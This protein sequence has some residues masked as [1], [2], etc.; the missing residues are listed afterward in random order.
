MHKSLSPIL[1]EEY[2]D[3]FE[4]LVVE[5]KMGG[6]NTRIISGYGPQGNWKFVIKMPFLNALEV[7]IL[8]AKLHSKAI[9]KQMDANNKL[10]P[11]FIKGDPHKQRETGKNVADI[12]KGSALIVMNESSKKCPG[13]ITRRRITKKVKEESI[14]DFVIVCEDMEESI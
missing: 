5:V 3:C 1:I 14:I 12:I 13:K 11:K 4:F 9:Y 10:G 7:E 6:R 8:N 2:S